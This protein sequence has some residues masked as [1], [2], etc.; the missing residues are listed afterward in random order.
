MGQSTMR[1]G[2]GLKPR[3]VSQEQDYYAPLFKEEKMAHSQNLI[4]HP[5]AG[6]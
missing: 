4:K 3:A 6:D 5:P 2:G 1:G